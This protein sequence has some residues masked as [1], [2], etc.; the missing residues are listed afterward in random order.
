MMVGEGPELGKGSGWDFLL[1]SRGAGCLRVGNRDPSWGS[2]T[3]SRPSRTRAE[4]R[5]GTVTSRPRD[6][7]VLE[8]G[9]C[10]GMQA[11]VVRCQN[12]NCLKAEHARLGAVFVC[13]DSGLQGNSLE[14]GGGHRSRQS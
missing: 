13:V 6:G 10:S 7:G 8:A 3:P 4:R 5:E 12:S 14:Q 9:V 2:S 11:G 1:R